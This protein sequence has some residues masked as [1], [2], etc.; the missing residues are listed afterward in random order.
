MKIKINKELILE[1]IT[2]NN[3]DNIEV[4]FS[5]IKASSLSTDYGK[6]IAL[7]NPSEYIVN[8]I[9]KEG[10]VNN[11]I[12]F[13]NKLKTNDYRTKLLREHFSTQDLNVNH[14]D[15]VGIIVSGVDKKNIPVW[16]TIEKTHAVAKSYGNW[17]TIKDISSSFIDFHDDIKKL[18]LSQ[19]LNKTNFHPNNITQLND[20]REYIMEYRNNLNKKYTLVIPQGDGSYFCDSNYSDLKL[21]NNSEM[22]K[23]IFLY[24]RL[25]SFIL[26]EGDKIIFSDYSRGASIDEFILKYFDKKRI[27]AIL[28]KA[29]V[30]KNKIDKYLTTIVDD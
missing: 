4:E 19:Y 6:M 27:E 30:P 14:L 12:K 17:F 5:K 7:N 15:N 10:N 28:N 11:V 22:I 9:I 3:I 21:I 26:L 23:N 13:L 20:G 16:M 1:S 29:S 2:F 18:N 25:P 8:I 24:N